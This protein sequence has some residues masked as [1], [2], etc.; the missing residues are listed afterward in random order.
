MTINT[1]KLHT[2][3]DRVKGWQIALIAI[4]TTLIFS[5]GYFIIS[6]YYP[7]H[8]II[9]PSSDSTYVN[10]NL[11]DSIY[12]SVITE[13]TTGYGDIRPVG[14][15]RLLV[16]IQ[17]FSGL[18]IAGILIAKITSSYGKALR[19]IQHNA[20]GYWLEPFKRGGEETMFTFSH[21]FFDGEKLR[22]EGDNYD[23]NGGYHGSF[24]GNLISIAGNYLK[25]EYFNLEQKHLF[26]SG[27]I[28]V[29]FSGDTQNTKWMSHRSICY[30]KSKRETTE[31]VGYRAN[32]F[33][34]RTFKSDDTSAKVLIIRKYIDN[35][36]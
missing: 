1:H 7:E 13:T 9:V 31:Y 3:I 5:I 4:V 20:E 10:V 36:K 28:E 24:R 17:V 2:F 15:S 30:D 22:Y 6:K 14:F 35:F 26:D 33:D 21:I 32:D 34:I 27:F 23:Y 11:L 25:F 12:F 19:Y 8:G 18:V 16:C 29:I